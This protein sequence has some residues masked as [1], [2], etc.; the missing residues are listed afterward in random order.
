APADPH[1]TQTLDVAGRRPTG[2]A[3]APDDDQ[4]GFGRTMA[5]PIGTGLAEPDVLVP[6]SRRRHRLGL[7]AVVLGVLLL[8]GAGIWWYAAEGPGAYTTVPQGLE[9]APV[10]EAEAVLAQAGLDVS[11]DEA[12][13]PVVPV[14]H[15]VSADPAPGD[16]VRKDG[17]VALVVSLG[18]DLRTVPEGLV[19]APAADVV[20]ALEAAGFTVPEPGREHHDEVPLDHVISVGAEP[21]SEL[22]VGTEVPVVVS[23]GRAPVE[24]I[25]V[26]GVERDA[27]IQE[28]SDRGLTVV[29]ATDFSMDHPAGTVMAQSLEPGSQALR[30]D[31]ITITVS[32]GPPLAAVPEIP[33]G[34]VVS[35]ARATLEAAGFRVETARAAPYFGLNRV[36]GQDPAAGTQAPLGSVVTLTIT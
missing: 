29:E 34:A 6:R 13:D 16:R 14:D 2:R 7:V 33:Y 28:L 12:F 23:D 10:A 35:D 24:V 22:P 25:S 5:L 11:Q 32:Q 17:T 9:G 30:L 20:A 15:V 3:P 8:A 36:L 27:A 18:P 19:G 31:E 21:L 26:V 1:A 4:P